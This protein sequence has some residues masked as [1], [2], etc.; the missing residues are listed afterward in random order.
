MGSENGENPWEIRFSL[1]TMQ[2]LQFTSFC[3]CKI[4]RETRKSP[5]GEW[6]L[7]VTYDIPQDSKKWKEILVWSENGENPW[8][9]WFS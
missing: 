4:P 5:M 7:A 2:K 1:I 6:G 8:E 9:I 3:M